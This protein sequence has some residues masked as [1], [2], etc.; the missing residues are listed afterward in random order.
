M[1]GR[2]KTIDDS[3]SYESAKDKSWPIYCPLQTKIT[4]TQKAFYSSFIEISICTIAP[5]LQWRSNQIALPIFVVLAV[6]LPNNFAPQTN[7]G[8]IRVVTSALELL[9]LLMIE[10][11]GK[12]PWILI[13]RGL[14]AIKNLSQ[15]MPI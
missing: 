5:Q 3:Y 14:L 2:F 10:E 6:V 4:T 7:S 13:I 11:L 15:D 9:L 8:L 1:N 12:D